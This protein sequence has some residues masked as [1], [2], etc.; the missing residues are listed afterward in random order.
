MRSLLH[1]DS[2]RTPFSFRTAESGSLSSYSELTTSKTYNKT[3]R[4]TD[5]EAFE[6]ILRTDSTNEYHV[7]MVI[8]KPSASHARFSDRSSPN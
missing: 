1:L 8:M 7:P 2:I 4:Q 5:D 6:N 3:S